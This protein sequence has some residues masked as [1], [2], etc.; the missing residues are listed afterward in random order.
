M[1]YPIGYSRVLLDR[2]RAPSNEL[3]V[4]ICSLSSASWVLVWVTNHLFVFLNHGLQLFCH[5]PQKGAEFT[6]DGGDHFL[7][8][9][10]PGRQLS[11]PGA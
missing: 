11:E 6:G 10:T 2:D 1:P 4:I 3:K 7:L 5:G 9:F 8:A